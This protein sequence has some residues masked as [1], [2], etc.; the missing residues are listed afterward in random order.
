MGVVQIV[1]FA[2]NLAIPA[3]L[4][5]GSSSSDLPT[6][7][8]NQWKINLERLIAAQGGF[9][10]CSR[11]DV[12]DAFLSLCRSSR[13]LWNKEKSTEV[14]RAGTGVVYTCEVRTSSLV[15]SWFTQENPKAD[16]ACKAPLRSLGLETDPSFH[17]NLQG[18]LQWIEFSSRAGDRQA[19]SVTTCRR[20]LK[21][22]DTIFP[23]PRDPEVFVK[24]LGTESG[25]PSD[26]LTANRL[27]LA[28]GLSS[29]WAAWRKRLLH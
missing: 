5:M 12:V 7:E 9:A 3:W 2:I 10:A 21:K 16:L 18:D 25:D 26:A 19:L 4:W 27:C 23:R 8:W 13:D 24:A 1:F 15:V 20:K 6:V 22:A 28:Y 29:R 11:R 17:F 14:E